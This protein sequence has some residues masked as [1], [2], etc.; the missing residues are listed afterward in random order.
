GTKLATVA[1]PAPRSWLCTARPTGFA[2]APSVLR[3]GKEMTNVS[4]SSYPGMEH[5]AA[6]QAMTTEA[7]I[8]PALVTA[9]NPLLTEVLSVALLQLGYAVLPPH[10]PDLVVPILSQAGLIEHETA[11]YDAGD[12]EDWQ[13]YLLTLR[14]T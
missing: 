9:P 8:H 14:I 4:S 11:L 2:I 6:A 7:E 13:P 3:R 10:R 12:L 5:P 1:Q